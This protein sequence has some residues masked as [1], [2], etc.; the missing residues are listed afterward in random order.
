MEEIQHAASPFPS[1]SVHG[2]ML[3]G[4]AAQIC[5]VC[6]NV[7]VLSCRNYYV[8][9]DCRKGYGFEIV[10]ALMQRYC[11]IVQTGVAAP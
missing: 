4:C 5:S 6:C 9:D 11:L 8:T 2:C 1:Y 3:L 10:G 7:C